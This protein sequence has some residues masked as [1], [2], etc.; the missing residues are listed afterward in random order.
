MEE[1][2]MSQKYNIKRC[3]IFVVLAAVFILPV[4]S[5]AQMKGNKLTVEKQ[6]KRIVSA[7]T[8]KALQGGTV[9]QKKMISKTIKPQEKLSVS[10]V[11]SN[12][13]VVLEAELLRTKN[14]LLQA[15]KAKVEKDKAISMLN[16]SVRGLQSLA[17]QKD[18]TIVAINQQL[19]G[20]QILVSEKDAELLN[21][22]DTHEK[23][24][25]AIM[26]YRT[27]LSLWDTQR[28]KTGL[29]A[30]DDLIISN[31]LRVSISRCPPI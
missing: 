12:K 25:S 10:A 7:P 17:N 16:E 6:V 24:N 18:T 27:A 19:N 8:G 1:K 2:K 9:P 23:Y 28:Q 29:T 14:T 15:D 13:I 5:I 21:L 20:L 22:G 4:S 30:E 31:E 26:C 11:L 3:A